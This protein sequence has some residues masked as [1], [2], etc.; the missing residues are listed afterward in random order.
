MSK[1]NG[2]R[3]ETVHFWTYVDKAKMCLRGGRF[4]QFTKICL[5]FS[6]VCLQFFKKSIA[7]QTHFGSTNRGSNMHHFWGTAFYFCNFS[8][9]SHCSD[10]SSLLNRKP[11]TNP[12]NTYTD[13]SS[14]IGAFASGYFTVWKFSNCYATLIFMWNQLW[15]ISVSEK[16]LFQQFCRLWILIFGKISQFKISK[17]TKN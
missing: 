15:L 17:N 7:S 10:K 1:V 5:H 13:L 12:L 8:N 6:A 16:L 9:G 11:N 3:A 2:C 4:F 14:L